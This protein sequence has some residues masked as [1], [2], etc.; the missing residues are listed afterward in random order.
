[1][2]H[3]SFYPHRFSKRLIERRTAKE[4]AEMRELTA[5]RF[6]FVRKLWFYQGDEQA[7]GTLLAML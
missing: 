4:T 5:K 3:A 1:M 7:R 2:L 6:C